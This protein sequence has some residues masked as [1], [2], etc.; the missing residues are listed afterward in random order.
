MRLP[1]HLYIVC[2]GFN[3]GMGGPLFIITRQLQVVVISIEEWW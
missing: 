1:S 3:T 2:D